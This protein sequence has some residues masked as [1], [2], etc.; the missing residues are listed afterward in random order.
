[1]ARIAAGQGDKGQ[2]VFMIRHAKLERARNG[3]TLGTNRLPDLSGAQATLSGSI[4]LP[5]TNF[6]QEAGTVGLLKS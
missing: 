3:N 1:M 2:T 5:A 6:T 4:P